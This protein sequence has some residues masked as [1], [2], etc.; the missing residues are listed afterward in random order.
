MKC[1]YCD[2]QC[3]GSASSMQGEAGIKQCSS[4]STTYYINDRDNVYC[5]RISFWIDN[6]SYSYEEFFESSFGFTS[7]G[8][9]YARFYCS[10]V[11]GHATEG[12][13]GVLLDDIPV[14]NDITPTNVVE[15]FKLYMTF[16]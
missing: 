6:K 2:E 16:S 5:V 4:C 14:P 1:K 12:W 10:N 15:K 9:S 7:K 8:H 13:G 11:T 3:Y